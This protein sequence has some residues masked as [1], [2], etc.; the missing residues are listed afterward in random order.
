MTIADIALVLWF[1]LSLAV[2]VVCA[3]VAHSRYLAR[4]DEDQEPRA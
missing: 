3:I 2:I 4:F 1:A